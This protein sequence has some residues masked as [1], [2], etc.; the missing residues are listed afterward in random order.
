MSLL[1][2]VLKIFTTSCRISGSHRVLYIGTGHL[3]R[4]AGGKE[5]RRARPDR[6]S[7]RQWISTS[8]FPGSALAPGAPIIRTPPDSD[9]VMG[10]GDLKI[11]DAATL[12]FYEVSR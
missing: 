10:S 11:T 9:P 5:I 8:T 2:S 7:Y 4:T 6:D 3:R 1:C 12:L